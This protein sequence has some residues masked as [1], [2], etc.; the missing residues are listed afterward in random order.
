ME[1]DCPGWRSCVVPE[2]LPRIRPHG[3][4]LTRI[5]GGGGVGILFPDRL[6]GKPHLKGM[7]LM[8]TEI[9]GDERDFEPGGIYYDG[10]MYAIDDEEDVEFDDTSDDD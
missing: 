2:G 3:F 4:A 6:H 1:P 9:Y 8:E 7:T 5:R 10:P